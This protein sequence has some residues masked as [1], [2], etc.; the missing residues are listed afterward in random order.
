MASIPPASA[1]RTNGWEL[2]LSLTEA[3]AVPRENIVVR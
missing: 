3:C 2:F 1:K